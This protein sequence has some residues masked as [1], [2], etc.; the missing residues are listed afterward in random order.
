[1]AAKDAISDMNT[2]ENVKFGP[3]RLEPGIKRRHGFSLFYAAFVSIGLATGLAILTPYVLTTNLGLGEGQQG[4]ALGTLAVVQELTLLVSFALFGALAD[5]I[6]RRTVYLLGLLLVG[7]AYALFAYG[8]TLVM[9]AVFRMIY[10]FGIG[11]VTGMLATVIADY[12]V[13]SDRGKLTAICGILN[14]LG[15]VIVAIFLGRLPAYFVSIG[16]DE[17]AAGRSALGVVAI[18][19]IV[20]GAIL[21]MTLKPGVPAAT[22]AKKSLPKLL[23]EGIAAARENPRIAISYAAAFVARGDLAIVGLFS[24][25]WGNQAAIAAGLSASEAASK[26]ALPFI[27]AQSAALLWPAIIAVPLDRM[28]RMKVLALTMGLGFVGYCALILVEDP[29]A[30]ASIG[31][32][33]LL[34]VGQIS[35]FLGAQ[36]II[37]K[38]APEAVRGSV[39]GLFNLSGAVGILVLSAVGGWLFDQIGPW[40][41]F[42]LVGLLNGFIAVLALVRLFSEKRMGIAAD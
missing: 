19:A 13:K 36:T 17:V 2:L 18:V 15:V 10:A 35:A 27:I 6:G 32:F 21:F 39:I 28:A 30:P 40:A 23:G 38:E 26:G 5:K 41:P 29:L 8:D 24:V 33:L 34:G 3:V 4:K 42:F 31:F 9:L 37:G 14:G 12:G 22:D 11:A 20:S 25:A 16:Q 1:M 7:T